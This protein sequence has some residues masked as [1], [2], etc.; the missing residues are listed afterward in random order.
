MKIQ[1]VK[2]FRP[3]SGDYLK[4]GVVLEARRIVKGFLNWDY[5]CI[6]GDRSG[7]DIPWINCV[8]L[9]EERTYTE[10][11][12][13]AL[14]DGYEKRFLLMEDS[15]EKREQ[16][17]VARIRRLETVQQGLEYEKKLMLETI[18]RAAV[19]QKPVSLPKDV[20][21]AIESFR[22]DGHDVD[23]I[24]KCL[25][26]G[27]SGIPTPR[28]E[29]LL[30]YASKYGYNLVCALANGYVI[31]EDANSLEEKL[32]T[33]IKEIIDDWDEE[34]GH[35]VFPRKPFLHDRIAEFVQGVYAV[36]QH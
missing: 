23:F 4:A 22:K 30:T 35:G 34:T 9:P 21:E 24:V 5:Q 3:I 26:V 18:E 28:K 25:T 32:R 29:A 36:Q 6:S 16:E 14:K 19:E 27:A 11:E 17:L 8:E 1:I 12:Y 31:E 33:G 2:G 10:S 7:T 13:N 20:A 15:H